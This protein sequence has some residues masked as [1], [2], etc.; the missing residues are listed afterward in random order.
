MVIDQLVVTTSN[1]R[2]DYGFTF[3]DIVVPFEP[4]LLVCNLII[5]EPSEGFQRASFLYLLE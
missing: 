3:S 1:K 2:T 5:Y 4:V